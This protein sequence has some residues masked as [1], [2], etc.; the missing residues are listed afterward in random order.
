MITFGHY[1]VAKDVSG[2]TTWLQGFAAE[3]KSRKRPFGTIIQHFG[4]D[5]SSGSF[6]QAIEKITS[7]LNVIH[8]PADTESLCKSTLKAL[9]AQQPRVFLPQ[10]LPSLHFSAHY[11][12]RLGLPW[13]FT[14]H[15]DDPDYWAFA[16]LVGPSK[17]SGA[18]VVV[19]EYLKDNCLAKYPDIDIRVIPYGVPVRVPTARWHPERFR[20]VYSGRMVEQQKR[21]SLVA[22]T[23]VHACLANERIEVVFIGDGADR[24]NAHNIVQSHQ[25]EARIRFAGRLDPPSLQRQLD[26]AHA[27][28]LM[29]D[30]E[31]LPVSLIEGMAKGLVPMAKYC[32][33]GVPELI[34]PNQTGL[35][36]QDDPIIAGKQIAQLAND[37]NTWQAYSKAAYDLAKRN[38]STEVCMTKWMELIDQLQ[39]RAT[40]QYPIEIPKRFELPEVDPRLARI[41]TRR[42]APWWHRVMNR[43]LKLQ[44]R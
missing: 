38:Y 27:I 7:S 4:P 42:P 43:F 26:D 34:N 15:S 19:S 12:A 31:G 39:A 16:D 9:N 6:F 8:L 30:Y 44:T 23:A 37:Q 13:V 35:I 10:C 33:S 25:L 18:W 32:K 41:D 14:M 17:Q 3:L 20:V 36:L 5:A 29:S 1:G 2:V 40:I 22:E 28:F 21:I 24:A 11:A